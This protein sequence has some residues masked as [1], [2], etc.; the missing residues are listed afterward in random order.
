MKMMVVTISAMF[1]SMA[2]AACPESET[3]MKSRE[4]MIAGDVMFEQISVSGEI[5][6]SDFDKA[7]LMMAGEEQE[8]VRQGLEMS[9]SNEVMSSIFAIEYESGALAIV[10]DKSTCQLKLGGY[11][12]E[13]V[14]FF[15]LIETELQTD[16]LVYRNPQNELIRISVIK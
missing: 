15:D 8:I 4:W 16:G 10:R 3:A 14:V 9:G 6:D 13:S 2:L 11:V 1:T 12:E 5:I 7:S